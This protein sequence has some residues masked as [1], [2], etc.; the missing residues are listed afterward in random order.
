[1]KLTDAG[2]TLTE[3]EGC[4]TPIHVLQAGSAFSEVPGRVHRV[5]N[6]G[7]TPAVMIWM[8]V[9]PICDGHSGIVTTN[10]PVREGLAKIP[11]CPVPVIQ[12]TKLAGGQFDLSF[13][14]LTGQSYTIE[15]NTNFTTTNWLSYTSFTARA[16]I[17]AMPVP[18]TNGPSRFFR[19]REP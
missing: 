6:N 9:Y 8:V 18:I 11:E 16:S 2:R 1:V 17:F 15:Q 14:T 7:T 13:R 4:G 3:D 12:P 5:S 19:I 10:G